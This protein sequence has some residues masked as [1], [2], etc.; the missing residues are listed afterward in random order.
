MGVVY[1]AEDQRLGRSV[2]LKFTSS[3]SQTARSETAGC[4][5]LPTGDEMNLLGT[6]AP[7]LQPLAFDLLGRRVIDAERISPEDL[8][9]LDGKSVFPSIAFSH[10]SFNEL[11]G[12]MGVKINVPDR[13]LLDAN[14]LFA[15]DD[16]GLR[17]KVTPLVGFEYSF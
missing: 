3:A 1:A 14:L 12:A 15:L 5:R 2:A 10:Q 9:A 8:H 17:D 6:G 13:L 16:H 7:G 4:S 11:S